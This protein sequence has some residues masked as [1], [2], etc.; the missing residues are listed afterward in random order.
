MKKIISII[1]AAVLIFSSLSMLA[2]AEVIENDTTLKFNSNGKFKILHIADIQDTPD[3]APITLDYI[4]RTCDA[5]KPDLIVLGGDNVAG[6][7]GKGKDVK[8][9]EKNMRKTLDTFMSIFEERNIPTALVFGNH[10][11]EHKIPDEKQMEIFNT[12]DCCIA[13]DEGPEVYGCGTYNIPIKSSDEKKIAYNIWCFDSNAYC[14][15]PGCDSYDY[16]RDDQI[17]WYLKKSNE[18]KAANGGKTVPSMV[19][20]HIIVPEI[21]DIQEKGTLKSGAINEPSH[22]SDHPS[23][24]LSA[25]LNQGDVKAMFFGHDHHNTFRIE[26]N[27]IDFVNTPTAGFSSYGGENRGIR[28]IELD[29]NDTSTYKTR[30]VNFLKTY[31]NNDAT[32]LCRYKMNAKEYNTFIRALNGIRYFYLALS[33]GK[34]FFSIC[35]EIHCII[36]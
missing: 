13:I 23:N 1:L 26:Y 30:L 6:A 7:A 28:V 10:D 31:C 2:S 20:Q 16:V 12:Y 33:E 32:Q 4:A 24:Q 14:D 25:I 29:E 19:F 22:P 18:L 21:F 3:V 36:N 17:A 15:E 5:E 11:G 8:E 35:K 34:S 9:A 27:G